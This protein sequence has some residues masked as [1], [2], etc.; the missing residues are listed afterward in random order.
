MEANNNMMEKN[1]MEN[2]DVSTQFV[3]AGPGWMALFEHQSDGELIVHAEPVI[4]WCLGA[5]N[6]GA[7]RLS[8]GRAVIGANPWIEKADDED[9]RHFFALVREEQLEPEFLTE[10]TQAG[11]R[12]RESIIEQ[13]RRSQSERAGHASWVRGKGHRKANST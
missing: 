13:A 2:D 7:H 8:F 10:L 4:A 11:V 5:E 6:S 1:T 12:S 9:A 3:P